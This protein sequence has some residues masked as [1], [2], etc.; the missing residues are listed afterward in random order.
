MMFVQ[1]SRF[2]HTETNLSF[3]TMRLPEQCVWINV[4]SEIPFSEE[5]YRNHST[6]LQSRVIDWFLTCFCWKEFLN[7]VCFIPVDI[8]LKLSVRKMFRWRL[9]AVCLLNVS[10]AI[11]LIPVSRGMLFFIIFCSRVSFNKDSCHC[12]PFYWSAMGSIDWFL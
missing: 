11:N 7:R 1:K 5:S 4:C 2:Q 10:Y 9:Q 8:V 12:K 3:S 6:N